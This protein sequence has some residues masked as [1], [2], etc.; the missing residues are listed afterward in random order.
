VHSGVRFSSD[1][2]LTPIGRIHSLVLMTV[3]TSHHRSFRLSD[4]VR[5]PNVWPSQS[6]PVKLMECP[7]ALALTSRIRDRSLAL[8]DS[9][10]L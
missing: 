4:V 7:S 3:E 6:S 10:L 1:K 5:R 8:G 2:S 9:R